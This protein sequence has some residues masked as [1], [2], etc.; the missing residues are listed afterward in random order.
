MKKLSHTSITLY[1]ECPQ[2]YKL[3]YLDDH[4]TKPAPHLN[5]GSAVHKALESFY[6]ERRQC[7][8]LLEHVLDV[9]DEEFDDEAYFTFEEREEAYADGTLMV[10]QFYQDHSGEEF[11]PPMAV[12]LTLRFEVE[13]IQVTAVIDRIDKLENGRVRIVDYKTGKILTREQAE[14]SPQLSLYQIAVEDQLGVEVEELQLYHVPSGTPI[15]VPRRSEEQLEEARER[16]RAV[17]RGVEAGEF[18]PIRQARCSWCDW[19]EHCSLFADWY[20]ENWEQEPPVPAPSRDEATALADRYGSLTNEIRERQAELEPVLEALERFFEQTGERAVAGEDFRLTAK[21]QVD[22]RFPDDEAL[23]AVLE[24]AGLWERV[25]APEWHRKARLMT[26]PKVP[27]D[28]RER[29]GEIA[30]EQVGWRVRCAQ[31]V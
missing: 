16:V 3:H 13:G 29:L 27:Q 23:R 22:W 8:P 18:E 26:D 9:F 25:L 30:D 14:A 24:P 31:G 21:R 5:K 19:R 10:Q 28:V 20:P 12:E 15:T 4:P 11:R 2:G 17:V 6:G 1:L 7:P